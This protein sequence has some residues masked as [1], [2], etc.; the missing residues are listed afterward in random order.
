[1][2]ECTFCKIVKGE[3]P[4][5]KIYEDEYTLAFPD[6]NPVSEGHTLIVPKRHSENLFEIPTEDLTAVHR[7]TQIVIHAIQDALNPIGVAVVQLNGR[8]VNQIIMHYHVH[9]IPRAA[10]EPPLVVSDMGAKEAD[11]NALKQTADKIA[12]AIK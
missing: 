8:G 5:F 12:A 11:M 6:I 4:S 9:L 1:M 2:E 10:N 7:A 3:I